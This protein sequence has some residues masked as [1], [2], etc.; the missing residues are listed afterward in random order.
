MYYKLIEYFI[1]SLERMWRD[2]DFFFFSNRLYLLSHGRNVVILLYSKHVYN[3][4]GK[5]YNSM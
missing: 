1:L 5:K 4:Y 2:K 3:E